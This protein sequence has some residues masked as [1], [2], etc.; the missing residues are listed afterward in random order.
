M[1]ASVR[2]AFTVRVEVKVKVNQSS[3][4]VSRVKDGLSSKASVPQVDPPG[5]GPMKK[6]SVRRLQAFLF[7]DLD[8]PMLRSKLARKGQ[9]IGHKKG[10]PSWVFDNM[11]YLMETVK[12]DT[13]G[14][15]TR[16]NRR[17]V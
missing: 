4:D 6:S 10:N 11:S 8:L 7:P 17:C 14:R 12:W 9:F 16:P 13:F 5:P 2:P 15:L 1:P 3:S